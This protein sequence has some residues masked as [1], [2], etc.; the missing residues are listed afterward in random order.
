MAGENVRFL[1]T[2]TENA[3]A[4]DSDPSHHPREEVW[5][6]ED[7]PSVGHMG[8][9]AATGQNLDLRQAEGKTLFLKASEESDVCQDHII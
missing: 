4:V 2:S 6:G 8:G 7:V 1:L 3:V 5:P 9:W